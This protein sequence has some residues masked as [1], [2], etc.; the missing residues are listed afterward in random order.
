MGL[1]DTMFDPTNEQGMGL[2]S[3]ASQILQGSGQTR[4]PYGL[5]QAMGDGIQSYMKGSQGARD[6][7]SQEEE[8]RQAMLMR[9]MQIEQAQQVQAQQQ[10]AIAHQLRVEDAYKNKPT[11][12]GPQQSMAARQSFM[13]GDLRPTVENAAKLEQMPE[14]AQATM[15]DQLMADAQYFQSKGLVTEAK[16]A[17]KEAADVRPKFN[18]TP[19]RLTRNGKDGMFLVNDYGGIQDTGMEVAPDMVEMKL[20]NRNEWV[21]KNRMKA[22][23]RFEIGVDPDTVYTGGITMRG[24]NMKDRRDRDLNEITRQGNRT[25]IINDPIQGPLLIDKGT[26]QARQAI[27]PDG[28]PIR[29]EAAVKK[30]AQAKGLSPILD[31]AEA[32]LDGATGSYAG[33]GYDETARFFGKST[34]GAQNIA[35]LK[36]AEGQ[37]MMNQPRMEGPQSNLDVGLYRQMAAQIGDPTVPTETKKA[38]FATLR[39]IVERNAGVNPLP[40]SIPRDA[41]NMLKMN[42]KLRAQ[43]DEKY[44]AGASDSVL[45]K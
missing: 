36:I 45:G 10:A 28:K 8:Q 40:A 1:L 3:A 27:G 44:G 24:Q 30:E 9:K 41:A 6:R 29:G 22:G 38:A 33:A 13:G 32:L 20:G 7:Q 16:N 31:A 12:S 23:Q 25:Q 26:A 35:K 18:T 21:D 42:P 11:M 37:I 4:Q 5:G 39:E 15:Y 14:Q 2:L 19:Q 43:F 17:M 34:G